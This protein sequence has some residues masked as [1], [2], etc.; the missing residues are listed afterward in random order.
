VCPNLAGQLGNG[1]TTHSGTP[2]DVSG[3]PSGR[4]SRGRS[5][6]AARTGAG[7]SPGGKVL[8]TVRFQIYCLV[9]ARPDM[10]CAAPDKAWE[11]AD[12]VRASRL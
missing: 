2:V 12:Q 5:L 10:N 3:L 8:Q 7:R 9:S 4:P 1:T 11:C 6:P